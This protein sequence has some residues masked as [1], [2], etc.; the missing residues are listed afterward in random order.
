MRT[1]HDEL[2]IMD[3]EL[4]ANW[5]I[6]FLRDEVSR[7]RGYTRV[8]LGL[9]GGIDSAVVA[10]LAQKA[11]GSENVSA[12]ALPYQTSSPQ[13]L[14]DAERLADT[15]HIPLM[16]YDITSA[17]E[18]YHKALPPTTPRRKG[19]VMARLRTL[20]LFDLGEAQNALPLG[21][22]NKTERLLG[23]FTW[24]ADDAPPVNP[25]GD[26]Y[27]T[28][29]FELARHLQIPDAFIEKPPSADLEPN[30]TDEADIGVS[31]AVADSILVRL[32][33]RYEKEEIIKEGFQ[34]NDVNLVYHRLHSTHWKRQPPT[35]AIL[36]THAIHTGFRRPVDYKAK[37]QGS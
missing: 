25:I 22:G 20:T 32:L 9:S 34:E 28:Q 3:P 4:T 8:I 31:Y 23:Y 14:K 35:S 17:V 18:A 7:Q 10:V 13:S 12:I 24:H 2:L 16:T 15:F 30:Q 19:N 6:R 29:V 37:E 26:L 11:F 27:K 1:L 5:L 33:H 21:T 36:T